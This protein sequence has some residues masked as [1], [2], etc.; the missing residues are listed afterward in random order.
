MT[1]KLYGLVLAGGRSS[2]MGQDKARL[3][4]HGQ[5]L[6]RHM[7]SLLTQAGV[8]HIL[9][10]GSGFADELNGLAVTCLDDVFPDRGPL[11]GLHA[12][13]TRSN[14]NDCFLAIPVD[15]PLVPVEAI[16]LLAR[17]QQTC[18]FSGFN[19]PLLLRVTRES[20]QVIERLV[21]SDDRKNY[22]LW[23]L[24]QQLGSQTLPTTMADYF[25]NAN[26]P[27]QWHELTKGPLR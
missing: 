18:S 9:L 20:R 19:L 10:S 14:D 13:I 22:A 2:R 8:E 26:T 21:N 4:W 3:R 12:A 1:G 17:Q 27:E 16:K 6:Y 24:L 11:G 5:P 25:V 7:I 15:M 23:R